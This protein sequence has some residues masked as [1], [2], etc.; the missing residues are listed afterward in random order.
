ML[1]A[2]ITWFI[3]QSGHPAYT[4][5]T[6]SSEC[7]KLNIAQDWD[8]ANDTDDDHDVKKETTFAGSTF[9]F[10]PGTHLTSE[11]SVYE[12]NEKF[13]MATMNCTMPTL[14]VHGGEY[15]NLKELKLEDVC[16]VQFP[17]GLGGPSDN[18]ETPISPKETYKHYCRLLPHGRVES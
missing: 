1:T 6:V 15:A 17:F 5:L 13:V 7:P 4:D 8:A 9:H 2:Q 3:E 12:T 14:H 11:N 16:L 10:A 18:R